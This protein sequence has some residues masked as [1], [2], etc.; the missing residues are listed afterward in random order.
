MCG[1][2]SPASPVLAK[3][4][5]ER[6]F[7]WGGLSKAGEL[8]NGGRGV[9]PSAP[10]RVAGSAANNSGGAATVRGA[11]RG[12]AIPESA[13]RRAMSNYSGYGRQLC[14]QLAFEVVCREREIC[15]LLQ[16]VISDCGWITI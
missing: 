3:E 5:Q 4:V 9:N 16:L 10:V 7:V 6:H 2:S 12:S 8:P 1:R 13:V 15:E 14:G 11:R